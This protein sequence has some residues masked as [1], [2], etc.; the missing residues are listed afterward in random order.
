MMNKHRWM[1]QT[2]TKENMVLIGSHHTAPAIEE[3]FK[4]QRFEWMAPSIGT[5]SEEMTRELII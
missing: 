3:L 1:T 4:K 5:C 2:V